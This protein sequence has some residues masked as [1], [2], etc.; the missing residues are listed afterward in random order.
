MVLASSALGCSFPAGR[1]T[2]SL[3]Q[4]GAESEAGSL[5]WY[6]CAPQHPV[7]SSTERGGQS[8]RDR[9]LVSD[10]WE[11]FVVLVPVTSHF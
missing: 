2:D 3:E 9:S 1:Q 8:L 4:H 10:A 11:L 6:P 5:G 7:S